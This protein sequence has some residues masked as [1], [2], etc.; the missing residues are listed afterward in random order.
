MPA[1]AAAVQDRPGGLATLE[2]Q[3]NIPTCDGGVE[4]RC[5]LP[6]IS[7][8]PQG[9]KSPHTARIHADVPHGIG[10]D[11]QRPCGGTGTT[12]QE[13]ESQ[14]GDRGQIAAP[15]N[16]CGFG[17]KVTLFKALCDVHCTSVGA[18]MMAKGRGKRHDAW[19]EWPT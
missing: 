7:E 18:A 3:F 10:T 14:G 1:P 5:V 2:K 16:N 15:L 11:G 13:L 17:Q 6:S 19:C 12:I 4:L 9:G 8:L